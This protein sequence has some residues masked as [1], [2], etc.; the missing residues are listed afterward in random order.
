MPCGKKMKIDKGLYYQNKQVQM[1][2]KGERG[3]EQL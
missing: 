3:A 1:P 2:P